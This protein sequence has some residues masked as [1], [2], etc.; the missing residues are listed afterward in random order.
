MDSIFDQTDTVLILCN[1]NFDIIVTNSSCED[2]FLTSK[3]KILNKKLDFFEDFQQ[4]YNLSFKSLNEGASFK[5]HDYIIRGQFYS[6]SIKCV[7]YSSKLPSYTKSLIL[8]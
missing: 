1:K 7:T 3:S 6:V 5:L 2:L 8:V 4:I